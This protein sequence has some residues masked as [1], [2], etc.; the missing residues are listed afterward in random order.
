MNFDDAAFTATSNNLTIAS[1]VADDSSVVGAKTTVNI[2]GYVVMSA[3]NTYTGGT[4]VDQGRVQASTGAFG[5][6]GSTVTVMP[7]GQVFFNSSGTYNYNW[8]LSG[9][10]TTESSGFGALRLNGRTLAGTITLAGNTALGDGTSTAT[11]TASITGPGGLTWGSGTTNNGNGTAVLN[12]T[13]PFTYAGDTQIGSGNSAGA[14]NDLQIATGATHNN[15]MP[16]GSGTGNLILF[17][18]GT[19]ETATFDLDGTSQGIDGLST[20]TGSSTAGNTAANT[21]SSF[22]AGNFVNNSNA[23]ASV[24]TLGNNNASA[25]FGGIIENTGAAGGLSI[26]KTGSGIQTFS[27]VNTYTGTT[28]INQGILSITGSLAAGSVVGIGGGTLSG[29]G[30][31]NGAVTLNSGATDP[32]ATGPGSIGTLTL[33]GGLIVNGGAMDFDLGANSNDKLSITG[34]GTLSL[35]GASNIGLGGGA[36][37]GV[38]TVV[39]VAAA[40]GISGTLPTLVSTAAS[41]LSYAYDPTSWS[42]TNSSATSIVVD[43]VGTTANLTWN[44]SNATFGG[45][46][47]DGQTWDLENNQNWNSTAVAGDPYQFFQGDSV[48]FNDSNNFPTNPNAYNV[49]LN[50]TV[51]PGAIIVNTSSTYT[52]S[53][54]GTIAGAGTL[55]VSGTGSLILATNNTFS[56][57]TTVAA[58]STLQLGMGGTTGNAGTGAISNSGT[59][60]INLSGSQSFPSA[61][62]G[63]GALANVGPGTV[64]SSGILGG[65]LN[66]TQSGNGSLVLSGANTYS[67]T[68]SITNGT[69]FPTSGASFGSLITGVVNVNGGAIDLSDIASAQTS[70]PSNSTSLETGPRDKAR[71]S[72]TPASRWIKIRPRFRT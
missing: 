38:Y 56:G 16:S 36:S 2:S 43:A 70:A 41:R 22:L 32:G 35:A 71:S 25:T 58:G 18:T 53:G 69:V 21:T 45:G 61:V 9:S 30:T 20:T 62:S 1:V 23:T 51:S 5:P 29:T 7:G 27:G 13:S 34:S 66:V 67:G 15:I 10:G 11:I 49:I 47:G 4:F 52:I 37:G 17:A 8:I 19:T 31:I 60:N 55:N 40:N 24:L 72:I 65:S 28:A 42:P 44:D 14:V 26:V 64:N 3:T 6:A 63:S 39:T 46:S 57:G 50:Q 54:T 59:V 68:T 12:E 48:T 33:A